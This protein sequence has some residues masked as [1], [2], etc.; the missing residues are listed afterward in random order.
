VG[1]LLGI[2]SNVL[3]GST[4]YVQKQALLAWPPALLIVARIAIALPLLIL[5]AERGGL[6]RATRADWARMVLVGTLG[7]AAPHLIGAY[8]LKDTASLN[9]ALLIG[10]E[11]VSIVLFSGLVLGERLML[12]Q[13]GGIACAIGGALFVV[14]G[15]DLGAVLAIDP[16]TRGNLL[17]AFHGTLWAIY[18]LASK[19]TLERVPSGTLTAVTSVIALL[20]MLPA[21]ALEWRE[22]EPARAF[23]PMP[24]LYLF[25]LG[26]GISFVATQLW[27]RALERI[28]ATQMA[29]L[30][31]LQ[32]IT[33]ALIGLFAGEPLGPWAFAGS[34]LV[35][36]G[37]WLSQPP[38]APA[39]VA[40]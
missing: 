15:G 20:T 23:A 31:F 8:G 39:S 38:T 4:Y 19:P 2:L 18:T 28:T 7:L 5:T 21:G 25:G 16:T 22:L 32:P 37:V 24:L 12:R 13:V 10:M 3:G 6:R 27:N 9:G 34:A 36:A 29:A 14:S 17:L 33:G 35:L 1:L 30:I 40:A 26:I 11:P